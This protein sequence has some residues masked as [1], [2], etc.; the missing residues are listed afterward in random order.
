[1]SR[2]LD[3]LQKVGPHSGGQMPNSPTAFVDAIESDFKHESA[4][5]VRMQVGPKS[6][7]FFHSDPRGFAAERYRLLRLRL[8]T[9]RAQADLK[10]ILI[11]SPGARDGKSTVALNL[12]AALAEK[13]KESVLLLE[14]DL[15]RPTLAS[16][17]GLKLPSGLTH[18]TRTELGLS[19]VI[20]RVEPLGFHFIPA[21]RPASNP[22]ELLN[23]EW[24]SHGVEKLAA[25]FDWV[26]IDSPP[27]IPVV[28]TISIKDRADASLLVIRAGVTQQASIDEAMRVLGPDHVLG[29][30]L[31]GVEGLDRRYDDYYA[32]KPARAKT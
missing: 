6:G 5:V 8:R 31:N 7:L 11:T 21:G 13:G 20:W 16:E 32:E 25:S 22:I 14:A 30:I 3:A 27:A 4:P 17:L 12:A 18:C 29:I 28:D 26:V 2:V 19:S 23:S 9:F 15:R 24:F 1:M 10:T